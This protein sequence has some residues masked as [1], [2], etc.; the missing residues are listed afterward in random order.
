MK[1]RVWEFETVDIDL[2]KLRP[3][4]A[5]SVCRWMNDP[6]TVKYLGYGFLKP[7]SLEEVKETIRLR[8]DGEFTGEELVIADAATGEYLGQI[9]LL[10][11]DE[12]AKTAEISLVLLPEARGQGI[13]FKALQLFLHKAFKEWHCQRL[14]LKCICA[15]TRALRLYEKAGFRLEGTLRRH[16]MTAE[17]LADVALYGM[18]KEEYEQLSLT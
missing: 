10:L 6:E 17:G 3:E 5:P 18:L 7:R 4:D 12:K 8:L 14:Y 11:P 1:K 13:A 2:R 9:N 15:N 16:I